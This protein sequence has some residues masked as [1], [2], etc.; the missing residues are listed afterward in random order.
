MKKPAALAEVAAAEWDRIMPLMPDADDR[1][2]QVIL[3]YCSL[4][5]GIAQCDAMI[6]EKGLLVPSAHG[7]VIAN[8]AIGSRNRFMVLLGQYTTML[9]LNPKSRNETAPKKSKKK[10]VADML[11]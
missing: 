4:V 3:A 11:E 10:T 1:D 9:G 8:P 6:A 2:L 5:E 7:G